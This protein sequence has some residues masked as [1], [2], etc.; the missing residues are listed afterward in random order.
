MLVLHAEHA[1]VRSSQSFMSVL[2]ILSSFG[3]GVSLALC[4]LV[5][6]GR[7]A[8][9]P[10]IESPVGTYRNLSFNVDGAGGAQ[11]LMAPLILSPNQRYSWGKELGSWSVREGKV[12][13]SER[14]SW[15][16]AKV[17]A[18]RQLLFEFTKDAK[19]YTVTMYRSGDAPAEV[20]AKGTNKV[21][22]SPDRDTTQAQAPPY[23]S[24]EIHDPD[25]IGKFYLGREIAQV[26]GHQGA[27]WLERPEREAE[28]NPDLLLD[29]LK[30]QPGNVVADI[31]AGTGYMSR[32]IAKKVG[33]KGQVLAVDIQPEMLMLLTNKMAQL[34]LR[35]VQPILGTITNPN[36]PSN[37]VDL[38]LMV[39]VYHEFD[40]PYEMLQAIC[41]SLRPGG[42][43]V[44]VEYR[45]ED[46][47][48]P[49][50]RVHKMSV[51]QARKEAAVHPLDW[52]E[53]IEI[54]PRQHIIVFKKKAK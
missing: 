13:L 25:G 1:N 34:N 54:L 53:T 39:D 42:R 41:T 10:R 48:V 23:E 50:K 18:D 11:R 51:E 5:A 3:A 32:R 46:P 37:S 38:V 8:E 2:K 22:A 4:C 33:E 14:P 17:N 31:G 7:A 47:S 19:H 52:V 24:R 43:V 28:E 40:H 35:N 45:A 27:D 9:A 6:P 49:I 26:M 44:F 12:R 36:L 20:P 16:D 15:G 30:L 21:P 29:S